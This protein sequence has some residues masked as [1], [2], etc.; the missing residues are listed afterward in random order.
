MF[1][2]EGKTHSDFELNFYYIMFK[3]KVMKSD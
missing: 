3:K 2:S 1:A